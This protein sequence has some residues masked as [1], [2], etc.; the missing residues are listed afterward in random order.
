MELA[1]RTGGG[2]AQP[3]RA[4]MAMIGMSIFTD[5]SSW[6]IWSVDSL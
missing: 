1:M 6:S 4:T 5:D 2:A 3:A